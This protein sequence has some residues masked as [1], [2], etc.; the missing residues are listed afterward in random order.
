M[1]SVVVQMQVQPGKR[2][3][4]LAAMGE[5]AASAVRDEPGCHRFDVCSVDGDDHHVV[6]Y[7]H[8]TD[9]AAF[10]AHRVTAHF[11]RWRA[12]APGVLVPG[13]QVTTT[14]SVLVSHSTERPA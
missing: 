10:D 5:N 9:A 6:L 12:A 4:F 3:E 11:L 7:E 8:Y 13:S 2:E 14:G 1:F